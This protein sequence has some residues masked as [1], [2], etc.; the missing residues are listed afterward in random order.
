[1]SAILIFI[2]VLLAG[3]A[4]LVFWPWRDRRAAN[5]DALNRALYHSRLRELDDE[6]PD[7]APRWRWICSAACWRISR[8]AARQKPPPPGAGCCWRAR[9]WWPWSASGCFCAPTA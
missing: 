6:P 9:C 5:R 7:A 8:Q 2:V 1:M 4:A 3:V